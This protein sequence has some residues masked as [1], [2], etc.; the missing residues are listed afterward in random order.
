[1]CFIFPLKSIWLLP[2]F[3]YTSFAIRKSIFWIF[4]EC[5]FT[6]VCRIWQGQEVTGHKGGWLP[7]EEYWHCPAQST[8]SFVIL[9]ASWCSQGCIHTAEFSM[10]QAS[11]EYNHPFSAVAALIVTDTAVLGGSL[12]N[13]SDVFIKVFFAAC[14]AKIC[15]NPYE[16]FM[17]E[18]IT[19]CDILCTKPLPNL[20]CHETRERKQT[21]GENI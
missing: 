21:E 19:E 9:K 5:W 12:H 20:L 10:N 7:M 18:Q 17:S 16:L 15:S 1:M 11:C 6:L 2:I 8:S 4:T 14:F 3:Y 13:E